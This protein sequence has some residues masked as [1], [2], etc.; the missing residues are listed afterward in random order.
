MHQRVKDFPCSKCDLQFG[1]N[2]SLKRHFVAKHNSDISCKNID[3][4]VVSNEEL[5]KDYSL[6]IEPCE[7]DNEEC[8]S[9]F[10]FSEDKIDIKFELE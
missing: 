9:E 10:D 1:T 8:R 4:N 3:R 7:T 5:S 2:S 6:K